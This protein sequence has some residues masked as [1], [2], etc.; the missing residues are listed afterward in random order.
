MIYGISKLYHSPIE[1]SKFVFFRND[2][3]TEIL[4]RSEDLLE[5]LAG[6]KS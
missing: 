5:Q 6:K 4:A 2:D 3:L 1:Q